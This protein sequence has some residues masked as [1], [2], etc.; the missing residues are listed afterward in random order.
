MWPKCP[1]PIRKFC[2]DSG[3]DTGGKA[4]MLGEAEN[5]NLEDPG[6]NPSSALHA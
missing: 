4:A 2:R 5:Q 1:E 3:M 6:W